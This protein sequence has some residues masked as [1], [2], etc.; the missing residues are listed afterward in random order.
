LRNQ[1]A[2]Q[3]RLTAPWRGR[4]YRDCTPLTAPRKHL[5]TDAL[6][7]SRIKKKAKVGCQSERFRPQVEAIS[8]HR[9][10]RKVFVRTPDTPMGEDRLDALYSVLTAAGERPPVGRLPYSENA[11]ATGIETVKKL[12]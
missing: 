8:E 7:F 9:V 4:E 2:Q 1:P 11:T 3:Q 6:K 5:V 10:D 12:V